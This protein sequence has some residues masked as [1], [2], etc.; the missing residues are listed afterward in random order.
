MHIKAHR[1]PS[2]NGTNCRPAGG[3]TMGKFKLL[4]TATI[5]AGLG[6]V[7]A[8][9]S[10]KAADEKAILSLLQ[11]SCDG[12]KVSDLDRALALYSPD[13]HLFDMAPPQQRTFADLKATVQQTITALAGTPECGYRDMKIKV[14]GDSAYAHY[15]M[16]YRATFK[17]GRTIE[18]EGR[19]TN[20]FERTNGKWLAVHEHL[21]LP[22]NM[23]TGQAEMKPPVTP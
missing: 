2:D 22:V 19:G 23:A 14:Y 21:S 10:S 15:I 3:N 7:S 16:P 18:F 8:C 13:L 1:V 5:I 11:D 4:I 20:I 9:T 12:F 6:A 17:D